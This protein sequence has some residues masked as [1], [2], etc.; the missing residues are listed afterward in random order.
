MTFDA[1]GGWGGYRVRALVGSATSATSLVASIREAMLAPVISDDPAMALVRRKI[2]ALGRRPLPDR[3]LA[4][5][6]QCT[7]EAFGLGSEAPPTAAELESWRQAAHGATRMAFS[8]AG[9]EGLASAVTDALGRAPAWPAVTPVPARGASVDAAAAVTYDAS[10]EIPAG[11]ARVIVVARTATPERA[12]EPASALGDPRGPL[13][14][15]LAALDFPARVRTVVATAH[16]DGGCVA[17]TVDLSAR[18]LERD[19]P[20]RIATAA[21]L[22][23][24][25]ITVELADFTPGADPAGE[26]PER[27]ADPRDAAERAAWWSLAG[28]SADA[29]DD[30]HVS[31]VVGIAAARDAGSSSPTASAEI[32]SEIDRATMAWH[33]PVVDGRSR[34]ERGQ[35]ETWVLLA[36]PCGTTSEAAD[37]G[38]GAAAAT[39]A[40]LQAQVTAGDVQVEPFVG[41]DGLGVL[42]H[43]PAK[44]PVR[45]PRRTP[46]GS[47]T[48]RRA[49]SRPTRW[50]PGRRPRR[51][52]R[53]SRAPG[54]STRVCSLRRALRS[55]PATRRGFCRWGR[56]SAS[57]R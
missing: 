2:E 44:I 25:E 22:A 40:A 39:A 13:A 8:I 51:V 4:D 10:G 21:A 30:V 5:V 14:S 54:V 15:R 28:R 43:G 55:P 19:A 46:A 29:G 57:H 6:A 31:L 53:C 1:V 37:A 38:S 50:P 52:R 45:A 56:A 24:Q 11:A 49:R 23:R 41:T 3:V 27:A 12:V 42:A 35:G 47:P 20:A 26:P 48:W 9:D 36:S 17:V 34:V 33:A 7:G 16:G 18:D 32:R